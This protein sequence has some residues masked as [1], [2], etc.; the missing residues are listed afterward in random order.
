MIVKNLKTITLL[1]AFLLI[2]ANVTPATSF[3]AD[4]VPAGAELDENNADITI[5]QWVDPE[6][7]QP[8][9][10][11]EFT[12]GLPPQEPL[13]IKRICGTSLVPSEK[14]SPSAPLVLV[15]VNSSIQ[16]DIQGSL[17]QYV[18]DLENEGYS[19]TVY[20]TS[21]GTPSDL[22]AYLQGEL[23]NGLVGCLLV[24]DLPVP[25]Y[26]MDDDFSG[27]AQFPIDLY[28]MDLDGTWTDSD[29]DG[30]YD[31]HSDGG[32]DRYPDIWV[33]RLTVNT[34]SGNATALLQNYFEKN[35]AYRTGDIILNNRALVYVDDDWIPWADVWDAD[36]GLAYD[37]RTLVKDG[38]TTIASDYKDR[39][40]DNYEWIQLCAHS[41]A[42]SHSFKIG[43]EWTGGSVSYTD[44]QSIDPVALF[45]N[46]FACSN[47]RYIETDYMGGWYV[48]A[49]T[50]GLAAVGST[51]TGGMLDFDKF[52]T[53]IGQ[54]K[55]LGESFKEW[56]IAVGPYDLHDRQWHYGMTLL[57]DPTLSTQPYIDLGEAVDNTG[58]TW[59]TDGNANWFGQTST[60][61][62]GG[63]AAQSGAITH[64]QVTWLRTTVTGP[65]SLSF[66]WK[67]SSESNFDFLR[68]YI[69]G[70]EQTRI[71][72]S[73]D[74]QQKSYSISSGTHN[75]EWRYT[76]DGSVNSGSDCGWVDKIE[77]PTITVTSPNGGETWA[78][79]STQTVRWTYTLNPGAY[80][81]IELFKGGVLNRT[82]SSS[83]SIG[84]GGSGSYSWAIPSTQ[85]S[86]T[87]YRVKITSTTNPA[88]T[89][90]SNADFTII[91][92]PPSAPTLKSPASASTVSSLTPRLEWNASSGAVSYGVQVSTSSSFASLLVNKTGITDLYYDIAPAILNWST[93]YYWRVNARNSFGSTSSWSSSWYFKTAVGPPP[94]APSDLIATPISSSQINLTWQDNSSDE[95]G[96][97]IERKTGTGSY[98]QIASV[99]VGVTSYSNTL[100]SANTTYYYR[101]RAYSAAGN[102]NYSNEASATTLPPPP[103]APTLKSPASGSTVS[104]RTPRLEWNAS[105]GAVSYG[106]QVATS[107]SFT[108]LLTNVIGVTDLYYDIAPGI[109]NWNTNYYWRV[110]AV[111]SF[112]ST[113]S[114]SSYRYFRTP[115]GP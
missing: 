30:L 110:N 68:F 104:N 66:Y 41:S 25:W 57:G 59:T 49:N 54:G 80:V 45:Y 83:M 19:V 10:Y 98:A 13:A 12:Q 91:G 50:Y 6:G 103:S 96:F 33:G 85:I 108:T 22:R 51:K 55:S 18:S 88:Y 69:D 27:Y 31:G 21:G 109:L 65:G 94:N 74:W 62:Y 99:G 61:Y 11:E 75:L 14:G 78:A 84:T 46:L 38:A 89:D 3:A 67:V 63:D 34:L 44:I 35:H 105:S 113:S 60:Y 8:M 71:S 5:L 73:I 100:L 4:P 23:S 52:Y 48:F 16:P 9:T 106:V 86:G 97:R 47:C 93:T 2:L 82:I 58:L 15:I 79:G 115:A 26:E 1:V 24:G 17:D 76:K 40:D 77:L 7:R 92:P 72:G 90:T 87:D 39:L 101:V 111:N 95:T 32:G 36:V 28:Y 64:N 20:A 107:S 37:T 112:G 102:S 29:V 70:V 42:C 43:N 56:F 81:K 114:W 53:P